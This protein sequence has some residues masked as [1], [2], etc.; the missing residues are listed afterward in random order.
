MA[1]VEKYD[2]Y[3]LNFQ[4]G[5]RNGVALA[6]ALKE[7]FHRSVCV[8]YLTNDNA[9]PSE[10]IKSEAFT[11]GFLKKPVDPLQL[12]DRL[13][14]FCRTSFSGRL[15]L[16]KGRGVRT[17]DTQD[18]L[19]IKANGKHA[20]F[21]FVDHHTENYC[22]LL[23]KLE[24]EVLHNVC[25]CRIHRSYIVNLQYVKHYNSKYITL[26]DGT[27]LPLKSRNFCDVYRD[28]LFRSNS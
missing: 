14:R 6:H 5:E 11:A 8:C 18:V 19:Y 13:D 24:S 4:T 27:V 7:K 16:K 22:Y 15:E 25:F 21:H 10:V 20:T 1:Q 17:I 3:F 28:Y 26:T 23:L 2:L 9:P 12:Q